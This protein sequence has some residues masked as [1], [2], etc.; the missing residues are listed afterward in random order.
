MTGVGFN[1]V[2]RQLAAAIKL[3]VEQHGDTERVR[4][5]PSSQSPLLGVIKASLLGG[6]QKRKSDCRTTEQTFESSNIPLSLGNAGDGTRGAA[7]VMVSY[8]SV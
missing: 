8:R 4:I 3:Y 6:C 5:R 7:N 1:A 2:G